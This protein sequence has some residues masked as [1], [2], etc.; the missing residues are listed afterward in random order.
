MYA[1]LKQ[2]KMEERFLSRV[3]IVEN[4]VPERFKKEY[5]NKEKPVILRGLWNNYPATKKWT[6]SYF[7]EQLGDIEVGVFDGKMQKEDRSF[8]EPHRK[9]KFSV[10]I[11]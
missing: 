10:K 11:Y 9:M 6:V 5:L 8:K 7:K 1:Y 2:V 4:I 3:D